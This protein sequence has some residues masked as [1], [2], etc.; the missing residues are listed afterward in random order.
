MY[1]IYITHLPRYSTINYSFL[2][3]ILFFVSGLFLF[4]LSS[5]TNYLAPAPRCPTGPSP[6]K[7]RWPP[8]CSAF[9]EVI[10]LQHPKT[11]DQYV[12]M[13]IVVVGLKL[14]T[15]IQ[16]GGVFIQFSVQSPFMSSIS[17][18]SAPAV[19]RHIITSF[20]SLTSP[21]HSSR[22]RC[23]IPLQH[24]ERSIPSYHD[25]QVITIHTYTTVHAGIPNSNIWI[26]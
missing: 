8:W 5:A 20:T 1:T 11:R 24:V 26:S 6:K 4:L 23:I 10:G 2:C 19:L 18:Y 13:F 15:L 22:P 17:G 12:S 3:F 16:P 9:T 14:K 21:Q 25:G 7:T